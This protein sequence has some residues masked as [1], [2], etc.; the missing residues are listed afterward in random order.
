MDLPYVIPY[1]VVFYF[2]DV[3]YFAYSVVR[4][5]YYTQ[6]EREQL[7]GMKDIEREIRKG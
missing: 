6:R 2:N 5:R 1:I 7:N 4:M 3:Q